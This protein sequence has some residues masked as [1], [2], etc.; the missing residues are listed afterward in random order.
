LAIFGFSWLINYYRRRLYF[1]GFKH[2]PRQAQ[3]KPSKPNSQNTDNQ[4]E[5]AEE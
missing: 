2:N 3:A 5:V 1:L 4:K